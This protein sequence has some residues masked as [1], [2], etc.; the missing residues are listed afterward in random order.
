MIYLGVAKYQARGITLWLLVMATVAMFLYSFTTLILVFYTRNLIRADSSELNTAYNKYL[1][2]QKLF[3]W[4]GLIG[5]AVYNVVH[6]IFGLKYWSLAY[7]V[8]QIKTNKNPDKLNRR[9]TL[10]FWAGVLLN[11]LCALLRW[12]AVSNRFSF[13][14]KRKMTIAALAFTTPLYIS[15][16]ILLDAFRRF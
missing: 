16:L 13:E 4:V 8:E 10:V 7:K 5:L 14:V 9:L 3:W 15:F 2:C 12:L 1:I 6:W 11:L